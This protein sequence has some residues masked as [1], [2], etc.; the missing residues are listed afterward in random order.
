[1][2]PN[3]LTWHSASPEETEH[4]GRTLAQTL[5][6]DAFVAL[7]GDLGAGKTAFVRGMAAQL[8]D[9]Y[10]SSPTFGIVHE[11]DTTPK[12]FHFDVY[13]LQGEEDLEAIGFEEYLHAGG[14][15]VVEWPER[16]AAA[17]PA[18]RWDIHIHTEGE[19][20]RRIEVEH[21]QQR[22]QEAPR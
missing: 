8:G 5:P 1:M 7:H 4:W 20:T 12:L 2:S 9:A 22:Q 16:I 13:R 3:H 21:K 17:L 11:Y 19:T 10:A 15:V 14:I 6:R 18:N